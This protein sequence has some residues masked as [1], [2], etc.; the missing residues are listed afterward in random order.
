MSSLPHPLPL[1]AVTSREGR[2]AFLGRS[3]AFLA[4]GGIVGSVP[5]LAGCKRKSTGRPD[6]DGPATNAGACPVTDVPFRSLVA[7]ARVESSARGVKALG[8]ADDAPIGGTGEGASG[9]PHT[10]LATFRE[11]AEYF[12][13]EVT[14]DAE[15]YAR[16]APAVALSWRP[17]GEADWRP[18][19]IAPPAAEADLDTF[20]D[21]RYLTLVR[22]PARATGAEVRIEGIPSGAVW[23]VEILAELPDT[24]PLALQGASGV[25]GAFV[26]P[27]FLGAPRDLVIVPRAAWNAQ[28]PRREPNKGKWGKVVVHHTARDTPVDSDGAAFVRAHQRDHMAQGWDDIGYN[29]L[30]APDGRVYEGRHGGKD[31]VG[32]HALQVNEWTVGVN[33]LGQFHEPARASLGLNRPTEAQIESGA[34]LIAWLAWECGIDLQAASPLPPNVRDD[35]QVPNLTM[36]AFIGANLKTPKPT[37]CPGTL[38]IARVPELRQKALAYRAQYDAPASTVGGPASIGTAAPHCGG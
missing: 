6:P 19:R 38:L 18:L 28:P 33:L 26:P 14:L 36:H 16:H 15:A 1:R 24:P 23:A 22:A 34:R 8:L 3:A 13:V 5:W 32:A 37:A 31:A 30:V 21:G 7:P 9:E 20:H 17:R 27:G 10:T 2:R 35:V 11:A 4:A 25:G 12:H 29:F